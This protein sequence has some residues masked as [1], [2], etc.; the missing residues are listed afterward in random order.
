M[1]LSGLPNP[2]AVCGPGHRRSNLVPAI[3]GYFC[4]VGKIT[5]R[6]HLTTTNSSGSSPG[7]KGGPKVPPESSFLARDQSLNLLVLPPEM[8]VLREKEL[9]WFPKELPKVP[10]PYLPKWKSHWQ[11]PGTSRLCP[12]L[13]RGSC[14]NHC[15]SW[16]PA[17]LWADEVNE[18]M[19]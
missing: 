13:P 8:E 1:R 10:T 12:Y 15:P 6:K 18:L 19:L 16:G 7:G 3:K 2:L 9:S 14:P 17:S 4:W 5:P 11:C